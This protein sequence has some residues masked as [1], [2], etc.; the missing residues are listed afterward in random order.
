MFHL[1]LL[2]LKSQKVTPDNIRRLILSREIPP[3]ELCGWSTKHFPLY[4]LQ[5][6]NLCIRNP[7]PCQFFQHLCKPRSAGINL[8]P[9][10]SL[11]ELAGISRLSYPM[12]VNG[13]QIKSNQMV[14]LVIH[15]MIYWPTNGTLVKNVKSRRPFPP[16]CSTISSKPEIFFF[17]IKLVFYT[18]PV[19]KWMICFYG[20]STFGRNICRF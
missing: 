13:L 17:A 15:L 7:F 12:A 18:K 14:R 8:R 10:Y 11:F 4:F 16:L 5:F 1:N 19:D 2:P 3:Q 20:L 6:T 9:F